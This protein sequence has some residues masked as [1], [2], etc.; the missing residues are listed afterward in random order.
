MKTTKNILM[1]LAMLLCVARMEAQTT[2]RFTLSGISALAGRTV[3]LPVSIDNTD[4]VVA[5][6][7]TIKVPEGSTLDAASAQLTNRAADHGITFR[8]RGDAYR[9]LV[10]SPTN[11]PLLGRTGQLLTVN[12]LVS[13][14]YEEGSSHAFEVSDVLLVMCDGS[15]GLTD[16]QVGELTIQKGPDLS[17]SA[18][19]AD[20]SDYM[21]GTTAVVTWQV[22]NIGAAPTGAGWTE[23]LSLRNEAGVTKLLS[24]T[25][26][27]ETL[28]P[29][30]RVSRQ[31]E[32]VLPT[33]LGMDGPAWLEVEVRPY[34]GTGESQGLR[35][36]NTATT[37]ATVYINK[38]LTLTLPTGAVDETYASPLRC[39]LTRSGDR[40]AAET[41]TIAHTADSRLTLPA[42]VTIPA[43]QSSVNFYAQLTDNSVLDDNG[44]IDITITGGGYPDAMGQMVIEDNEYPDLTVQSSAAEVREGET[45]QLTITTSRVA[46]EDIT[47]TLSSEHSSRFTWPTPIVIPAGRSSATVDVTAVDDDLPSLTLSSAFRANAPAHNRGQAIVILEDDDVPALEL[48]LTPS[49][50]S[51]GDGPVAVAAVLRRTGVTNNKITVRLSDDSNGG[52]YYG[53]KEFELAKGVEEA[54]FNLG[55]I[56]NANVD[57]DRVVNIT[58]AVYISSCS[59]NAAG[60]SAGVVSA[61][62]TI[63]DDDGPALKLTS[64]VS[65]LKEGSQTT[66]TVERNTA[67]SSALT[68]TL[69]SDQDARLVYDHNVT[70]PAGQ[71][72]AIVTVASTANDTQGDSFTAVFTA[73]AEGFSAGTC[74]MMVTDQSLPDAR[75]SIA[76]DKTEAEVGSEVKLTMTVTNTGNAV[77]PV[78]VPVTVHHADVQRDLITTRALDVGE[79]EYLTTTLNLP[80][81]IGYTTVYAVVNEKDNVSELSRNNNTSSTIK[82]T[83]TSPY[84]ATV[85]LDKAIYE[86]GEAVV[87][88]GSLQGNLIS[89][90]PVDVYIVIGGGRESIQTTSDETGAFTA[91]WQPK[92][93]IAGHFAV[94]AC[95]PGENH[96]A[97]SA[98]FDVHGAVV[99]MES[100]NQ[101]DVTLGETLTR[102]FFIRNQSNIPLTGIDVQVVSS[103]E[104]CDV[105][106]NAP[107]SIEGQSQGTLTCTIGGNIATS[108]NRWDEI[109]LVITTSEGV[110][111]DLSLWYYCRPLTPKLEVSTTNIV[112]TMTKGTSREYPI[113]ITNIGKAET[114]TIT[115]TNTEEWMEPTT[116]LSMPS[117]QQGEST[118][119]LLQLTPTPQM[120]VN[121]SPVKGVFY[122]EYGKGNNVALNYAITPVSESKGT[123]TVDVKDENTFYADDEPHVAGATVILKTHTGDIVAQA[124]TGDDG[125]CSI[126]VPEGPYILTVTADGH[127]TKDYDV[128]IDPGTETRRNILLN[129]N[130]ITFEHIVVPTTV[131]E[132]Y[133]VVTKVDYK[134]NVPVPVV[135]LTCPK[136]IKGDEM[137]IGDKKLLSFILTNKGL[138]AAENVYLSIPESNDFWSMTAVSDNGPFR[139]LPQASQTVTVLLEK[140]NGKSN[141]NNKRRRIG[142]KE[143]NEASYKAAQSTFGACYANMAYQ[144]SYLCGGELE[145]NEGAEIA[146]LATCTAGAVASAISEVFS[147]LQISGIGGGGGGPAGTPNGSGGNTTS[148]TKSSQTQYAA[149]EEQVT[150]CDPEDT[151]CGLALIEAMLGKGKGFSTKVA[152]KLLG[153]SKGLRSIKENRQKA[154]EEGRSQDDADREFFANIMKEKYK[155]VKDILKDARQQAAA[156]GSEEQPSGDGTLGFIKSAGEAYS[157]AKACEHTYN[158]LNPRQENGRGDNIQTLYDYATI[159]EDIF[160]LAKELCGSEECMKEFIEH[161]DEIVNYLS[162]VN[163]NTATIESF[164]GG[165]PDVVRH[166]VWEILAERI[167]KSRKR[168]LFSLDDSSSSAPRRVE[169]TD[170]APN[171][172]VDVLYDYIDINRLIMLIDDIQAK[173]ASA[174]NEG[175]DS[176]EDKFN[177]VIDAY[178][179]YYNDPSEHVCATMRLE[180]KQDIYLTREAFEG[181]LIVT[182]GHQSLPIT[183][184][185]VTFNVYDESGHIVNSDIMDQKLKQT[186]GLEGTTNGLD[187]SWTLQAQQK[188]SISVLYTPS[189]LAAPTSPQKYLFGGTVYYI[190]P[191]T[192]SET[193]RELVPVQLTVHPSPQLELTYFLQRNIYG[194]DPLTED[195]EAIVPAEFAVLVNNKGYGEAQNVRML[196]QQPKIELNE[197]GLA[198]E[199]HIVSSQLNGGSQLPAIGTTLTDFGNISAHSQAYAQWWFTSNLLGYFSSYDVTIRSL[200]YKNAKMALVNLSDQPIH[201][202]IRS[203]K[204]DG[205]ALT[206]FLVNDIPD[207]DDTPDMLY[208]TNGET[209][210]VSKASDVQI[211]KVSATDYELTVTAAQDGWTYGRIVDPTAGM[212]ELKSVVRKRDGKVISLRNFWQTDRTLIDGK[213]WLYDNNLHFAD[214]LSATSETYVLTFEPTPDVVLEVTDI[215][216]IPADGELATEPVESVSVTFSKTIDPETFTA[217][218]ITMGVQAVKQDASLIGITTE[219]NRTFTLDLSQVNAQTGNGYYT[220]SVLTADITDAEGFTGKTG[221]TVGWI[222][223]QGGLVQLLTSVYPETAGDIQRSVAGQVKARRAPAQDG[224]KAEYGSTVVFTATPNPGYEFANWSINGTTVAN[225]T[226]PT[227]TT[228]VFGDMDVVANFRRRSYAVTVQA[229]GL[230][231]SI[232]GGGTGL[233]EFESTLQLTAQP[234]TDYVFSHWTVNG[235]TMDGG[236]TLTL[237]VDEAK[238]VKAIFERAF[239]L[240][241]VN[242]DG[243]IDIADVMAMHAHILQMSAKT[244]V[245]KAADLNA[246]GD[247][248]ITDVMRVHNLI[249]KK[250]LNSPMRRIYQLRM[251]DCKAG[252]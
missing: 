102:R 163:W 190:D 43:G 88:N 183:N 63:L 26:Y 75:V 205:D 138:I 23:Y 3:A 64:A 107:S 71:T 40:T 199:F 51:E 91:T 231:G 206:G 93:A 60:E 243:E 142:A 44:I 149:S 129:I 174:V 22:G 218:D 173:E 176:F 29:S 214:E 245:V 141:I 179:N 143:L 121:G 212:S 33:V 222:Y 59:C 50:V 123:L 31:V 198:N 249:L 92:S 13:D 12:M 34:S 84:T 168:Y 203:I 65:T 130:A 180:F 20:A 210:E 140:L 171:Y 6:E 148:Q 227:L 211:R 55:P 76:T 17:V 150:F 126:E 108:T 127:N 247:I 162:S 77:L 134:T 98:S 83:T 25:T 155:E 215:A 19:G 184:M 118:T 230:G 241:D 136:D 137:Q 47:V 182:N 53:K 152:T 7:F 1:L 193:H 54:H 158:K 236:P 8:S 38:V 161:G 187:G 196:T 175:Y 235:E 220:L 252:Q 250:Q 66:F 144:Y 191:F 87:V 139:L 209:A 119:I 159:P 21:P 223:F 61:P 226:E 240:G 244:F 239:T 177:Q 116:G 132:H 124:F 202:L 128:I 58:A 68:L 251:P 37:D 146:T 30:A 96:I 232:D 103:P 32:V 94:G 135:L 147:N 18:V 81:T 49:Q 99:Y 228:E 145:D 10:F 195:V 216:G 178:R 70:I 45:F 14:A 41:F 233:Y 133:E 69:T 246:D 36:N 242:G 125:L 28:A 157:L 79:T 131:E 122:I 111:K 166:E 154:M 217:D 78:G 112:T 62:L 189:A 165:A 15:N 73:K 164:V 72:K 97:G 192:G 208:L 24:T 56:D 42:E 229:D 213:E 110:K 181:T 160:N 200:S 201:E 204:A 207:T 248:D 186:E 90:Q 95:Y 4:E 48:T 11:S 188:G 238:E 39:T 113:T 117:L 115:I 120:Q 82:L 86:V 35:W 170:T 169:S 67:T 89:K 80:S 197:K 219:D 153:T 234:E 104:G 106:L 221:K 109:K 172:E 105:Q 5:V 194:D 52:I 74:Y 85:T 100:T 9:C 114:G 167:I 224:D 2:N 151:K 156:I 237:K 27:D 185:R 101:Y 46:T 16:T 57:G 225:A